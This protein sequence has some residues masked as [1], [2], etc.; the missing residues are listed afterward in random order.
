MLRV[1]MQSHHGIPEKMVEV[2][3]SH[4]ADR[5]EE[6]GEDT[7]EVDSTERDPLSRTQVGEDDVTDK[8]VGEDDEKEDAHEGGGA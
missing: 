7:V 3:T 6:G 1:S 2:L 5:E 4:D 8:G